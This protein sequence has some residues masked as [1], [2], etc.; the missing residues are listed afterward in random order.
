MSRWVG[1]AAVVAAMPEVVIAIA[2]M[3]THLGDP[4][5]VGAFAAGLAVWP[6]ALQLS[7]SHTMWML[8][9]VVLAAAVMV[10]L[11]TGIAAP[12]PPGATADGFGFP[13]GHTLMAT[14]GYGALVWGSRRRWELLA[15]A[16]IVVVGASRVLIGAHYI[17]D[18]VAGWMLGIG[19]LMA[20]HRWIRTAGPQRTA[21]AIAAVLTM[22]TA[23]VAALS[24]WYAPGIGA[25]AAAL[26]LVIRREEE[27]GG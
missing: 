5:V 19:M 25:A 18:V 21:L 11:K 23:G 9:M 3:V 15:A 27:G 20:G 1:E 6:R 7:R 2:A 16:V 8:V 14:V 26:A 10:V 17:V 22:V 12:R 24:P 13:S 4:L